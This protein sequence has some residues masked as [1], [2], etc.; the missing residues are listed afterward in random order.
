[1]AY[2][3]KYI[4]EF[5]NQFEQTCALEI[6][7]DNEDPPIDP[8]YLTGT[9]RPVLQKGIDNDRKLYTPIR[10]QELLAEIVTD[11]LSI[12]DFIADEDTTWKGIF[13][14]NDN[15]VFEGFL[16]Q[17]DSD[18][19]YVTYNHVIRLR[20]T[21]SLALLKGVEFRQSN[22]TYWFADVT[23]YDII[24]T[25]L[26]KTGLT[27]D[28]TVRCNIFPADTADVTLES[29]LSINKVN[30]RTFMANQR[31]FEDCYTVLNK[32]M[33]AWGCT[34]YQYRGRWVI[35]RWAD[36]L[37]QATS[38]FDYDVNGDATYIG[39]NYTDAAI[40]EA[41]DIK[42]VEAPQRLSIMRASRESKI[43]YRFET[44]PE[45]IRNLDLDDGT[46]QLLLSGPSQRTYSLDHYTIVN[47]TAYSRRE[48]DS[49]G[50]ETQRYFYIEGAADNLDLTDYVQTS[51]FPAVAGDKLKISFAAC[52]ETDLSTTAAIVYVKC[53][54]YYLDD[55]GKWYTASKFLRLDWAS[56]EDS[57]EW[58]T[59][60]IESAE[61]PANGD[62]EMR[63]LLMQGCAAG[64]ETRYKDVSVEY[65]QVINNSY[66]AIGDFNLYPND[67][68]TK[69]PIE[70]A[71]NIS[72]ATKKVLR[73]AILKNNGNLETA[74]QRGTAAEELRFS[75]LN[76]LGYYQSAYRTKMRF[77]GIYRGVDETTGF[78]MQYTFDDV[79]GKK[80][81]LAS[82][83]EI[84]W[85]TGIWRG[86]MVEVNDVT[87]DVD[88]DTLPTGFVYNY[89]F[90]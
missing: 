14:V 63:F 53:G 75:Q 88:I 12:T 49:L 62:V 28:I 8:E 16:L 61:I 23:F 19:D 48:I 17:E 47:R 11:T 33:L 86:T 66:G 81:F 80:F 67:A 72:D 40:G 45:L 37:E 56:S 65:V 82:L 24:N 13:K 1:M 10:G 78:K 60:E 31:D 46:I 71:V 20:F 79:V 51:T 21:D 85:M 22:G 7:E 5:K 73:G 18:E 44:W 76:A 90:K 77:E 39:T 64:N 68:T 52:S 54:S 4:L 59:Y 84:D 35:E 30:T 43:T 36:R 55:D 26:L 57:T 89:I 50:N 69:N 41:Q 2:Q 9:A 58:K 38:E 29:A 3:L 70:Q 15:T 42:E 74:W 34:L 25:C 6:Y 87:L 32:I 27:L 83:D